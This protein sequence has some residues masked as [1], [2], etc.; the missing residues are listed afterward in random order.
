MDDITIAKKLTKHIIYRFGA[1]I[2]MITDQG[3]NYTS[4]IVQRMFKKFGITHRTTTPYHPS[5]NGECER[6]N[7]TLAVQ[8]SILTEENKEEGSRIGKDSV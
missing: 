5:S 4:R 6:F 2:V 1:P 7:Q 3:T 8:L